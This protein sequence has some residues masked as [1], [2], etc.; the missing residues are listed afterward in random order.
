[1][2]SV[3]LKQFA[4]SLLALLSLFASAVSACTCAHHQAKRETDL[5][6]CHAHPAAKTEIGQNDAAGSPETIETAISGVECFCLQPAPKVASKAE[7]VKFKKYMAAI[8]PLTSPE[9]VFVP[10]I[11]AV[12][13][14]FTKP[15]Y[16]SD[17]FYNLSPG[18]APPGI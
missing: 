17:S 6:A 8:S 11:A 5:P 2:K 10:Q 12:R 15:L 14:N 16:L 7:T 18:R 4:I 3:N 9:I 13:I 1:M